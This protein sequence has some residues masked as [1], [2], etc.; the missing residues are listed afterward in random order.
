MGCSPGP[1]ATKSFGPVWKGG[2]GPAAALLARPFGGARGCTRGDAISKPP[3]H[4][5]DR[6]PHLARL[7]PDT[8]SSALEV[9]WPSLHP[10]W[11][12]PSPRNHL[13]LRPHHRRSSIRHQLRWA[14][15]TVRPEAS[16][17][18]RPSTARRLRAETIQDDRS[19]PHARTLMLLAMVQPTDVGTAANGTGPSAATSCTSRTARLGMHA[20]LVAR[21][22]EVGSGGV[23]ASVG[24]RTKARRAG[25]VETGERGRNF[26]VEGAGA[27]DPFVVDSGPVAVGTSARAMTDRRVLGR[28]VS[29][30]VTAARGPRAVASSS[31]G[32]W[33]HR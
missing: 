6:S 21:G 29:T 7:R 20:H 2:G 30:W 14:G 27:S 28:S 8:P 25:D 19:S 11:A 1:S 4:K 22:W 18:S 5:E 23:R 10:S 16:L 33:S 3:R 32:C 15:Q 12:P 17:R 31:V 26:D 13:L 9:P 24:R